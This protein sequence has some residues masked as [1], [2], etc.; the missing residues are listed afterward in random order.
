VFRTQA[1]TVFASDQ[2]WNLK[3]LVGIVMAVDT[4][5]TAAACA[6]LY[7]VRPPCVVSRPSSSLRLPSQ[8]CVLHWGN[9]EAE[10]TRIYWPYALVNGASAITAAIV[11][12]YLLRRFWLLCVRILPNLASGVLTSAR[13]SRNLHLTIPLV[14]V[15]ILAVSPVLAGSS[16]G[17]AHGL[18]TC[19]S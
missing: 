3:L 4:I 17:A 14:L 16:C 5:G 13:R 6:H 15:A 12:T 2:S 11:H 18:L 9:V 8:N 7:I 19:R 1:S 10:L